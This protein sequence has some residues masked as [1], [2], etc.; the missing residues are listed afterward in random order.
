VER[1]GDKVAIFTND[2]LK[3]DF[4]TTIIKSYLVANYCQIGTKQK[5]PISPLLQENKIMIIDSSGFILR[6]ANLI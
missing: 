6:E 5:L 2:Q 1:H 3:S 4:S